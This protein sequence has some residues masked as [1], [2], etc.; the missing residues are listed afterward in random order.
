MNGQI[1]YKKQQMIDAFNK[2]D[3]QEAE[4][5]SRD[6]LAQ[7]FDD[8][9]SISI[10]AK[11][12]AVKK[13]YNISE[14]YLKLCSE[15]DP[16]S[17][18]IMEWIADL[19]WLQGRLYEAIAYYRKAIDR[20]Q[21]RSN[22]F[23]MLGHLIKEKQKIQGKAVEEWFDRNGDETLRLTYPIPPGGTVIDVGGFDGEWSKKIN[24]LYNPKLYILEPVKSYYE[25]I[26]QKFQEC[27]NAI[28][29]NA[30]LSNVEQ[31]QKIYVMG[32]ASSTHRSSQEFE[33]ILLLEANKFFASYNITHVDLIKINIEGG[34]YDLLDHMIESGDILMC[35]NIQIQFHDFVKEAEWRRFEIRKSLMK[36]HK[37]TWNYTFVWEN[38]E[39]I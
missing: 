25:I 24:A 29:V 11:I 31:T 26:A 37:L 33:E 3:L 9:K 15:I 16:D 23:M 8:I 22:A 12:Y 17:G 34:E 19:H 4:D 21:N 36:T 7:K 18:E 6:I 20:D 2:G 39:K 13:Q 28:V 32:N 10:L 14:K 27:E 38:W 5:I 30:G 35:N 1:N